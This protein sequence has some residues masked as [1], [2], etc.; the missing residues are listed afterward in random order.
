MPQALGQVPIYY[1]HL[2]TGR[3]VPEGTDH[4]HKYAS[5]YLDVRNDPLYPFGYGLTYTTFEYGAP[6]LGGNGSV[7]LKE[8]E[9]KPVTVSVD[10]KNSGTRDADEIVQ[11]YIRDVFASVSR[12]VK[13][14]KGFQRIHLKAGES[15][16]VNFNITPEQ[17][18]FYDF[19]GNKVLEPGEFVLMTGPNS[20]DV[21]SVTLTVK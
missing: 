2:N 17:L 5:N 19:D 4:Y 3:P 10:V 13:E 12:P 21:Q 11:L 1:N 15:K 18:S 20:R 7:D 9:T 14:L 16:T 8:L 6:V